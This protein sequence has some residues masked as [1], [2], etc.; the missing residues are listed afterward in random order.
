[1]ILVVGA[2]IVRTLSLNDKTL[3]AN[4]GFSASWPYGPRI[5]LQSQTRPGLVGLL[6]TMGKG[7]VVGLNKF[8]KESCF[9]HSKMVALRMSTC[10]LI[11]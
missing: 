6:N 1:M 2:Y 7:A 5:V 11:S 10:I 8:R 9:R 3:G 4:S